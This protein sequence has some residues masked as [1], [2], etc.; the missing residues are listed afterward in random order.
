MNI[1]SNDYGNPCD[2]KTCGMWV[3]PYNGYIIFNNTI[4][5]KCIND[6]EKKITKFFNNLINEN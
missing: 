6:A 5:K 3:S 2:V 4:C 1:D